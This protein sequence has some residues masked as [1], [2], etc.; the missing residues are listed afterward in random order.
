MFEH[1]AATA[2]G[3]LFS[4]VAGY[5]AIAPLMDTAWRRV[6]APLTPNPSLRPNPYPEHPQAIGILERC[7]YTASWQLGVK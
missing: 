3:Y 4:V 1:I 5:W 6:V 2:A 7:L